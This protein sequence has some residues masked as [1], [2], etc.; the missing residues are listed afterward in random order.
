[1]NYNNYT[2]EDFAADAYFRKWVQSPDVDSDIFWLNWLGQ[3]P[4]KQQ[5]VTEAKKLVHAFQVQENEYSEQF[6]AKLWQNIDSQISHKPVVRPLPVVQ[7][8]RVNRFFNQYRKMAAA[9]IFLLAAA[10]LFVTLY[11]LPEKHTTAFGETKT[12]ILPDNS[13]VTLN[14]NSTLKYST[15]WDKKELREVWLEGE[16]YFHVQ[17]Q[18]ARVP[19]QTGTKFIVHTGLMDV[20]VLGTEFNVSTR[21]GKAQVVL[22]SGKVKL[23]SDIAGKSSTIF[24]E[25]GELVELSES[26]ASFTKRVVNPQNF[27]AWKNKKLIF[28]KT[29][30]TEIAKILEDTYGW[31]VTIANDQLASMTFTSTISIEKPEVLLQLLSESFHVNIT[32]KGDQVT[33][34]K[35][36]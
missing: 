28:D 1:M 14:A 16:A 9:V 11:S 12:I 2:S 18:P 22:N 19:S 20:E 33:I 3:N 7:E 30:I 13:V 32:K 26:H 35:A 21:R 4:D 6:I 5:T 36:E 31:K 23:N 24:M 34:G 25:P 17:K 27:S 29:P 15:D 10:A 8:N